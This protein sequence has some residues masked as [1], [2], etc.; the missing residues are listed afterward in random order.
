MPL[1]PPLL[2]TMT[3]GPACA[4]RPPAPDSFCDGSGYI[5]DVRATA[6]RL[7]Q[8]VAALRAQVSRPARRGAAPGS[9][10]APGLARPAGARAAGR[11]LGG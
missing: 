8:Q 10:M 5:Q 2:L 1:P 3:L 4:P 9:G 11:Q 6:L 7:H